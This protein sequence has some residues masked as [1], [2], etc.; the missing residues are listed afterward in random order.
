MLWSFRRVYSWARSND[1]ISVDSLRRSSA[2][3]MLSMLFWY[4][5]F[6]TRFAT[7]PLVMPAMSIGL[8]SQMVPL[9]LD[10]VMSKRIGFSRARSSRE[11][12]TLAAVA[13]S[14]RF[15]FYFH[16]S[17][18]STLLYRFHSMLACNDVKKN[19]YITCYFRST[20]HEKC[21]RDRTVDHR[22]SRRDMERYQK[23]PLPLDIL[24]PC[25]AQ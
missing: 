22:K 6:V 16:I 18:D 8:T 3:G 10:K 12:Q 11:T 25:N 20:S 9:I 19:A 4:C 14:S 2:R 7:Q 15:P 24:Y 1:R 17:K 23:H 21:S 13:L 5:F